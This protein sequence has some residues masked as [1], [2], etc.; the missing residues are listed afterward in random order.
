MVSTWLTFCAG[1]PASV[2]LTV[3]VEL[4]A[5]VGVPP[6]T[7]PVSDSPAGSVPLIE[8]LYG[9]VPPLAVIVAL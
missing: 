4:P 3:T 6:T 7:H 5:A 2:T 9:E 1:E 8:Q